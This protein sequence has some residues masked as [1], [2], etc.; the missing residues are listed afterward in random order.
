MMP[1]QIIAENEFALAF[2]D[3]SPKASV[4]VLVIPKG[5]FMDA[6]DFYEHATYSQITGFY[7]I[8]IN[9]IMV[10]GMDQAGFKLVTRSGE[11]GGQE[12]PHFHI[13]ILGGENV[14]DK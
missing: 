14:A 6:V 10:H 11:N 5:E 1:C 2:E 12:I 3:A 7:K 9:V 4:H 13:H 8:V